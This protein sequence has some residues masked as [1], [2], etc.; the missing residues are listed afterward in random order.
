MALLLLMVNSAIATP[1]SLSWHFESY[2]EYWHV[3]PYVGF[4]LPEP[5]LLLRA[6][7]GHV[8]DGTG[9]PRILD[10]VTT[11][12][13]AEMDA[14]DAMVV[15]SDLREGTAT[16][17]LLIEGVGGV[18]DYHTKQ[19]LLDERVHELQSRAPDVNGDGRID[20]CAH[21]SLILTHEEGWENLPLPNDRDPSTELHDD[22]HACLPDVNGDGYGDLLVAHYESTVLFTLGGPMSLHLGGPDG[23]ATEPLWTAEIVGDATFSAIAVQRDIDPE[24]EIALLAKP[25][26]Y[27][28]AQFESLILFIDD[29][30]T[31][32]PFVSQAYYAYPTGSDVSE[33]QLVA[34]GD[35]DGDGFDEIAIPE[36]AGSDPDAF[37]DPAHHIRV[38][39]ATSWNVDPDVR[40]T[41]LFDLHKDHERWNMDLGAADLNHDGH[42]DLF[43]FISGL[44]ETTTQIWYGPLIVPDEGDTGETGDTADTGSA[45]T[46]PTDTD[47]DTGTPAVDSGTPKQPPSPP[48]DE[49]T[50]CGCTTTTAWALPLHPFTRRRG[51]P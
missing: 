45:T 24:L 10:P 27:G 50:G 11:T 41:F 18:F 38:L 21:S 13:G 16:S 40:T 47:T 37:D 6:Y 23:Y 4:G 51:A 7:D 3:E 5:A 9:P 1:P 12:K 14:G 28:W 2:D 20:L 44:R 25:L 15:P 29:V 48:D 17:M 35:L 34:L 31:T 42:I 46:Q 39:S 30:A 36:S 19:Q 32:Q 22:F 33:G 26:P 43:G 8:V 49:P